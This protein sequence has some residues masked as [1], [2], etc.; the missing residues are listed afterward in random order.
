LRHVCWIGP[1]G[2]VRKLCSHLRS[3]ILP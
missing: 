2:V 3:A 1:E